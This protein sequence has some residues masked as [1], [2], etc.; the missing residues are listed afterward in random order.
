M[1]WQATE[2]NPSWRVAFLGLVRRD[3]KYGDP[4]AIAASVEAW[5]RMMGLLD[6]QLASNG[7]YAIGATFTLADIVLGSSVNRWRMTPMERPHYP[8]VA[9]Y[10]EHLLARSGYREHGANGIP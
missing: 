9:D 8:A 5:N 4:D 10:H 2:L 7:A 1:D 3:P 6:R